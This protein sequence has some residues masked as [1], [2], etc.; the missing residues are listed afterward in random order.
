MKDQYQFKLQLSK[1]QATSPSK[2]KAYQD[3]ENS[4]KLTA[5]LTEL[6]SHSSYQV[7]IDNKTEI[8]NYYYDLNNKII[9]S[10]FVNSY[11]SQNVNFYVVYK[12]VNN[13]LMMYYI[14]IDTQE[15]FKEFD[16]NAYFGTSNI[17]FGYLPLMFNGVNGA[18]YKYEGNNKYTTY[19]Q[20]Y[21]YILASLIPSDEGGLTNSSKDNFSLYLD[22]NNKF[23]YIELTT[24]S[25]TDSGSL[26]NTVTTIKYNNFDKVV[27]PD[28]ILN[29]GE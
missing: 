10:D 13:K 25:S 27:I 4:V 18:C 2:I 23:D 9:Y 19:Y 28:Y 22:D 29:L 26:S 3:D 12:E 14:N 8:T 21:D 20:T 5:A 16:F 7:I 15:I 1:F 11:T 24:I 6:Q 17:T